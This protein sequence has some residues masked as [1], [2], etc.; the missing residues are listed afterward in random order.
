MLLV[1]VAIAGS[2]SFVLPAIVLPAL[3]QKS[4]VDAAKRLQ[5]ARET[6]VSL[7]E[8][9]RSEL[10]AAIKNGGVVGAMGLCQT[11]SPD[12][13]TKIGRASCRERVCLA[14]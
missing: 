7:A 2:A 1:A 4:A 5:K 9:L 13:V 10:A 3:A 11:I 14:V 12:L 6:T 8:R